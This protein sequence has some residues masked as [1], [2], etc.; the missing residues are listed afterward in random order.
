MAAAAAWDWHTALPPD[1]M[2]TAQY[3]GRET[4]TQCHQTEYKLWLGSDHDRAMELATRRIGAWRLQRHEVRVPRRDDAVLPPRR[5][6]H[7]QHR[8]A[9]RQVPR[10]RNQVHV[11][12]RAAA[13]VHGRVS[14]GPRAGAPRVV[15]REARSEW[16][17]VTP[18]DVPNERILP[19]DPLHWT[20]IAP[21]LEHDLR[22][23]PFDERA[24]EL[25]SEDEHVSH[26]VAGDRRQ[27]RRV[28][29]AGQRAR[30]AGPRA[31]RCS[32]T[33]TSATACRS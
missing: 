3:V 21:E 29:R 14:R 24:Q 25:R 2:R 31:G 20:G 22:R 1:V 19:G 32:G 26:D 23:L 27:L 30:R 5:Q 12:R 7:G 18:P 17:D 15:G 28:P 10:L 8:R 16:F 4:C 11:R 6:V 13:A 9:R 33:A